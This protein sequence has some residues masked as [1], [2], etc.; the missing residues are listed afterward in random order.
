MSL[1]DTIKGAREEASEAAAGRVAKSDAATDDAEAAKSSQGFSR[2]SAARAKPTRELA[3]SVRSGKK[4]PSEMS[5]EEKKAEREAKRTE[6]D[7]LYD[8]KKAVLESREDYRRTQKI[9][10]GLVIAGLAL[11]IISF[12]IGRYMQSTTG[13]LTGTMAAISVVL[14]VVAYALIIGAFVYDLVKVRPLRKQ[15]DE[16]IL[17]MSKKRLRQTIDDFEDG[18]KGK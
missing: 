4:S 3:G 11:S 5:K 7:L 6:E 8:A 13:D 9:W 1:L 16:K 2:K 18:K 17:G 15:A 10:W 14:M 12:G